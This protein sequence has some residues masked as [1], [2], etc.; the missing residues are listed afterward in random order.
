MI[1]KTKRAKVE[2]DRVFKVLSSIFPAIDLLKE[3]HEYQKELDQE[4]ETYKDEILCL[5]KQ[6]DTRVQFIE[7][8]VE[9]MQCLKSKIEISMIPKKS[10]W[11]IWK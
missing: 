11:K 10:F 6:C 7:R 8:L 9:D 4:K 1:K 3:I 2:K 5:I